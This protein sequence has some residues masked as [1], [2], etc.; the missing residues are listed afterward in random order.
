MFI[1][2]VLFSSIFFLFGPMSLLNSRYSFGALIC[3]SYFYLEIN[4][5]SSF[6]FL[7]FS[8]LRVIVYFNRLCVAPFCVCFF[9]FF[10]TCYSSSTLS[11]LF[12]LVMCSTFSKCLR[13]PFFFQILGF[14]F[15]FVSSCFVFVC[16]FLPFLLSFFPSFFPV[17]LLL[18]FFFP[19]FPHVSF[20]IS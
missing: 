4:S 1:F 13:L 2:F 12:I 11:C 14:I 18:S 10:P 6:F 17:V 16:F 15:V 20:F 9:N 5:Y 3:Y 19:P 8:S 7:P